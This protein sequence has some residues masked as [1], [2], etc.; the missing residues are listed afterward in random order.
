MDAGGSGALLGQEEEEAMNT[1]MADTV[2]HHTMAV[3]REYRRGNWTLPE[4]MLLI[5]AKKRV[6]DD[7]RP[8]DQGWR[9]GDGWRTTAGAVAAGAARTSATTVG[10]TS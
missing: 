1:S 3:A 10:T 7:R 2:S 6:H 8:A 9:G 5:E 4:T